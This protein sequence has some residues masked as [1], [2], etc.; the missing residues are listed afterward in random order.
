MLLPTPTWASSAERWS[1]AAKAVGV[2]STLSPEKE[3]NTDADIS[4]KKTAIPDRLQACHL[5]KT[6]SHLEKLREEKELFIQ[7]TR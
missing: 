4:K 6:L 1:W 3:H 2:L 7:K 5:R